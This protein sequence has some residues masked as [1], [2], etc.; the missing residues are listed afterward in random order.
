GVHAVVMLLKQGWVDSNADTAVNLMKAWDSVTRW[1]YEPANKA[2]I[3]AI[4]KKTMGASDKSAEA[5]YNLHVVAKSVPQTL[6]INEKYMQQFLENQKK[7]GGEN[8]PSDAM[9]YVD[10]SL[11]DKAL[12]A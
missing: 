3:I 1:I 8:L 11:V 7:A 6:R 2:E 9:K 5:V 12:K 4:S 10:S